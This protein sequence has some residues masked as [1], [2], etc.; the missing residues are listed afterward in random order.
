VFEVAEDEFEVKEMIAVDEGILIEF[1][2]NN[3]GAI[4]V[5]IGCST[6]SNDVFAM[7]KMIEQ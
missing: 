6:G 2:V 5:E 3:R 7:F 1:E 4:E